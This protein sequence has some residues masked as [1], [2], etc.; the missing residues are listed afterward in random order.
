MPT[1][2]AVTTKAPSG[3]TIIGWGIA[4]FLAFFAARGVLEQ[5]DLSQAI[6]TLAALVP[7]PLFATFLWQFIRGLR[8]ADELERRIHLEALAVAFPLAI[9]LLQTLGLLQRAVDL[10]FEDWSY[11]HVW[12]Y[13]PI[14]YVLGLA[15]A[16]RRYS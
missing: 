9:L 6:R 16:R 15:L 13:L 8:E 5:P 1:A 3:R 12:V 2:P 7:V 4:W 10:K 11:M 14:F